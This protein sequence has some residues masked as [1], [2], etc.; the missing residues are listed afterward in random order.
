MARTA[1]RQCRLLKGPEP[2]VARTADLAVEPGPQLYIDISIHI[3]I[4]IY[5]YPPSC[6]LGTSRRVLGFFLPEG[7]TEGTFR[8]GEVLGFHFLPPSAYA[9]PLHVAPRRSTSLH[10]AGLM[11]PFFHISFR[12]PQISRF[13][14]DVLS[15]ITILNPP[16]WGL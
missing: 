7:G 11:S 4:Y 8:E 15:K 1:S 9:T 13:F 3:C 16:K 6:C 14:K 10:A 2:V 5:I 12:R